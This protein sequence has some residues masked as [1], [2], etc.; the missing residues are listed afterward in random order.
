[1]L[2][3]PPPPYQSFVPAMHSVPVCQITSPHLLIA[4][5]HGAGEGA[6]GNMDEEMIELM[7]TDSEMIE[8][9]TGNRRC[10]SDC[11]RLWV[12]EQR[13]ADTRQNRYKV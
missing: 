4:R 13:R 2:D 7:S 11:G 10:E 3:S 8:E 9:I 5:A 6:S 1:M 12:G